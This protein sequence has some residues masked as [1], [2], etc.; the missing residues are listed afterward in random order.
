MRGV[1]CFYGL[2]CASDHKTTKIETTV[3]RSSEPV[4]T[5]SQQSA[6]QGAKS[7]TTTT[8]TKVG[9]PGIVSSTFH[10]IGYVLELPFIAIGSLFGAIFGG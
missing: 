5:A 8:D 4:A 10:A 7:E 3:T 9:H 6:K 1:F 2:G